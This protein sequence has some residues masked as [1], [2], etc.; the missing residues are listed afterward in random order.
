MNVVTNIIDIDH[1]FNPVSE[2]W[3]LNMQNKLKFKCSTKN[4]EVVRKSKQ[5]K[6]LNKPDQICNH[7][8]KKENCFYRALSTIICGNDQYHN[9]LRFLI[10]E[11][12]KNNNAYMEN[13]LGQFNMEDYLW[14]HLSTDPSINISP[15]I[16]EILAAAVFLETC[17]YEYD[18]ITQKW[19]FY[20]KD[21]PN[22]QSFSNNQQCIY[23]AQ[24]RTEFSL[25]CNVEDTE[26]V[27]T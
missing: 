14:Q 1:Y 20:H 13:L 11:H 17:I 26:N 25:V 7:T 5:P 19:N 16:V 24:S 12:L 27:K 9:D 21:W 15:D 8:V 3:Q 2:Q 4:F 23:I 6:L 22:Y 18:Y 10:I